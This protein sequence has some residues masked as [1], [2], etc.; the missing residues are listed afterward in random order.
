MKTSR[1]KYN[2]FLI[3]SLFLVFLV[4]L[5]FTFL[6]VKV[7]E[8]LINAFSNGNYKEISNYLND[9]VELDIIDQEGIYGKMQ[10]EQILK[11]FFQK[12]A[13]QN[14]SILHEGGKEKAWYVIG[15]LQTSNGNFRINFLFK[16]NIILQIRIE[17]DNGN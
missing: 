17:T 6:S 3:L 15:K 9:D 4:T 13:P 10:A 16:S 7:P 1:L 14:F 5:S 12:N 2:T 8:K 11:L